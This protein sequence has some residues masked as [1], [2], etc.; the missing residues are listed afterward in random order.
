M[1]SNYNNDEESLCMISDV[2]MTAAQ[3][4]MDLDCLNEG[5]SIFL[6]AGED[7]LCGQTYLEL[8]DDQV[9]D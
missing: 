5:Q 4:M 3:E 9:F 1:F 2:R 7:K 6:Y 8:G